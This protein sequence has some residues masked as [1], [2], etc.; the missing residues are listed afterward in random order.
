MMETKTFQ[1]CASTT[2]KKCMLL[3]TDGA[4][5]G[6]PGPGGWAF[7]VID[8]N[9][10]N[11]DEIIHRESGYEEQTTNNRMELTAVLKGLLYIKKFIASQEQNVNSYSFKFNVDSKYVLN[12]VVE[13]MSKW[14]KNNWKTSTKSP[15]LNDDLWKEIDELHNHIKAIT[16]VSWVWVKGHSK[17]KYNDVVD[18]LAS[19]ASLHGKKVFRLVDGF[20]N[21]V[22]YTE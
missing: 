4:C 2:N 10:N 17:D 7:I 14:K 18:K 8:K 1:E 9:V 3:Y 5:K 15:V 11:N 16:E 6:N 13:W 21:F 20:K 22:T 19:N 12:G